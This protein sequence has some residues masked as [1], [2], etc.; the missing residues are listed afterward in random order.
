M[1]FLKHI[2]VRQVETRPNDAWFDMSLRKLR[3]GEVTF[4]SVK[5]FLTGDW[6][7]K[8]C[9]DKQEGRITIKALKCPAG[10]KFSQLEGRTMIFQQSQIPGMFYDVITSSE[11]DRN[12]RL[13]RNVIPSL[14]GVPS[15]IRD[16]YLVKPYEEATGIRAIG[17]N[18]VTLTKQDD[19]KDFVTLFVLERAWTLSGLNPEEKLKENEQKTK[20]RKTLRKEVKTEEF[21]TCP[22]CGKKNQLIH[23]ETERTVKHI[24]R[25][26]H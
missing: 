25:K 19:E 20:K 13:R 4:Y 8:M 23:V 26:S 2:K 10:I 3:S 14:E 15:I 9:K 12:N 16:N 22:V 21:A 18:L 17:K 7:F 6:I 1:R 5:D 24:L 11:L